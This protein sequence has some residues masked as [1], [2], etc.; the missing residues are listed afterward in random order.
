MMHCDFKYW[1]RTGLILNDP[2]LGAPALALVW[3]SKS[4]V[5]DFKSGIKDGLI[6]SKRNDGAPAK[7][8]AIR[9]KP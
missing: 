1:T 2:V 6:I 5:R 4:I 7:A 8:Y 3:N 9:E